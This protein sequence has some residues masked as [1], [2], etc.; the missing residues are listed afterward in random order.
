MI[1]RRP[2]AEEGFGVPLGPEPARPSMND[3]VAEVEVAEYTPTP[4]AV[5]IDH[6]VRRALGEDPL[7]AQAATPKRDRMNAPDGGGPVAD[8]ETEDDA[9]RSDS[10]DEIIGDRRSYER[11]FIVAAG[12]IAAMLLGARL[13]FPAAYWV[14]AIPPL[15]VLLLTVWRQTD[16]RAE[17]LVD[18]GEGAR[19]ERVGEWIDWPIARTALAIV[20]APALTA[21][22][23]GVFDPAHRAAA[24]TA[25]AV[26]IIALVA[27]VVGV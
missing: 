4:T 10:L 23:R 27:L 15:I 18:E 5:A 1:S 17:R 6:A 3:T 13:A 22:A 24:W 8:A 11:G 7:A 26:W 20:A 9:D 19:R 25:W 21:L 2:G 12:A 16:R 14:C